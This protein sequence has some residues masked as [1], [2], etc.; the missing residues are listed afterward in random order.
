M[1]DYAPSNEKRMKVNFHRKKVSRQDI[2]TI[3]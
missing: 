1:R 2:L 3:Q